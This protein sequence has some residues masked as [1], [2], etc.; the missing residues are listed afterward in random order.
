MEGF[1]EE[2]GAPDSWE[3]ADLDE[4][5]NRLMVSSYKKTNKSTTESSSSGFSLPEFADDPFDTGGSAT[6]ITTEVNGGS[7]SDDVGNQVDQFLREALEKP[8]ERLSVLRMERD[9]LKFIHDPTKQQ[10]E[11]NQLPTSYL[12]LAAHRVA[13]HYFL[14]STGLVDNS[15]PDGSSYTI[16]LSKIS[17]CR[18][19]SIRL[20]DVPAN[21]PQ[22]DNRSVAKVAIKKRPNK[23]SHNINS[24]SSHPLKGNHTKSVE[25]RKEEYNRARARIFNT[26]N[27]CSSSGPSGKP[28]GEDLVH[29]AY[30]QCPL[31]TSSAEEISVA[32][33]PEVSLARSLS[34]SSTA[35]IRSGRDRADDSVSRY[36]TN[37]GRVAII[38]DREIDR[39]DPDYDRNYDRYMQRFDPGFGFSGA[40]YPIQ[41][42]YSPAINYNTEFPQLGS[43]HRPQISIEH[44]HHQPR[45]I[46]HHLRG[47]T[48]V[49]TSSPRY[50]PP[51]TMIAAPLN[52][53][54]IGTHPSASTI[55]VHPSQYTYPPRP[56]M[57]FINPHEHVHLPFPQSCFVTDDDDKCRELLRA[58][59]CLVARDGPDGED[60]SY[61]NQKLS[62]TDKQPLLGEPV[63][64]KK[65]VHVKEPQEKLKMFGVTNHEVSNNQSDAHINLRVWGRMEQS[66]LHDKE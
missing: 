22:E 45:P 32:V 55:Y 38:R 53:N 21:L 19:P 20:A 47:G 64:A 31:R 16:V 12:R 41:P 28:E 51:E 4:S 11:F 29:D 57:Q 35:S 61:A 27:S 24:G 40:L 65:D 14:H 52:P 36:S 66:I 56:Q 17:E 49:P 33:V 25:E 9:V 2:I 62:S 6:V 46:P 13:Q 58:R 43:A 10:L 18:L 59:A 44:H 5:M 1:V 30:Q 60:P 54:H 42:M 15:L 37:S 8:R 34:D 7:A 26:A 48:W 23:R 3:M 50:G 63:V 39:K